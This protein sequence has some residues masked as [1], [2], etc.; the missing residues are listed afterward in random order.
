MLM[1]TSHELV[2]ACL[3]HERPDRLPAIQ[4]AFGINDRPAIWP[5][6]AA[7]FVPSVPRQD[8]W[9]CIWSR[10]EVDNMGQVTGHPL[11]DMPSDLSVTM[12][13]D[14][15]DPSHYEKY[16]AFIDEAERQ[17]KYIA[18]G[19]AFVLFERMHMLRGFQQTLVD[20]LADPETTH[21]LAEHVVNVQLVYI[22]YLYRTYG[23]RIHG[24]TVSDDF[25]TQQA[26]FISADVWMQVFGPHYRRLYGAMHD[27][28]YDVWVHSCGKVNDIIEC[29]IDVGVDVVNLQQPRALGIEEIGERYRGRITF[30]SL[31]DIQQT[32]P[33]ADKRLVDQDVEAL[34][35]H[36]ASPQGGFVLGEYGEAGIG[37][38]RDTTRYMYER[39]SEWSE[40]MYGNPLP[41]IG[42]R[43]QGLGLEA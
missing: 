13:P 16:D 20:I 18:A 21:R 43:A 25:G 3:A 14:Y 5:Q 33:K 28:G 35:R 38:S 42:V 11:V 22:D 7:S 8:E 2:R 9:G 15:S 41:E 24:I 1:M 37:G 31:C 27:A 26:P 17:H 39:F 23:K 12:Y 36:W 29:Y 10:T 4:N 30:E 34:M 32:L 6:R 40:R 19:I